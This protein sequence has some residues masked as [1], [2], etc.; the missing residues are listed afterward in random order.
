M[1]SADFLKL[2]RTDKRLQVLLAA[3]VLVA[4]ATAFLIYYNS[5]S[6]IIARLSR[7]N[8][9]GGEFVEII[10]EAQLKL[11]RANLRPSDKIDALLAMA[12]AKTALGDQKG[13][14][15]DYKEI[16]KYN[17]SHTI[18]HNNL[19][20]LYIEMKKYEEAEYEYLAVI[21]TQPQIADTYLRLVDLYQGYLNKKENLIPAVLTYA[22]DRN[23]LQPVFLEKLAQY[24]FDKGLYA[25]SLEQIDRLLQ[26]DPNNQLGKFLFEEIQKQS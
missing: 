13:A 6:Q 18:S 14:I 16:F 21:A 5:E 9:R 17:V 2:F 11:S 25:Q 4:L 1:S 20:A 3:G 10:A 12:V 15:E 19:A 22:I 7:E 24:Y 26:V 8:P 23:G